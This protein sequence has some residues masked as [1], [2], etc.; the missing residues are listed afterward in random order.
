MDIGFSELYSAA[1]VPALPI[2]RRNIGQDRRAHA[3]LMD[4]ALMPVGA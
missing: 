1:N 2:I 4:E 3:T